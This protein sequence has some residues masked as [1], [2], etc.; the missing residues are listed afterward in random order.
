M[1]KNIVFFDV[2]GGRGGC[3]SGANNH[4][5]VSGGQRGWENGGSSI[6]GLGT[7]GSE[8]RRPITLKCCGK[9]VLVG[10]HLRFN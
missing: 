9:N 3:D 2:F 5:K 8:F 7:Q 10:T 1:L 4:N 6:A